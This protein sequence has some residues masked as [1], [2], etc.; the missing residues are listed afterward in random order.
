MH[1]SDFHFELPDELIARY[2]T[3]ERDASRLLHVSSDG[4]HHDRVFKDLV[5]LISPNDCLIFNN[6]KVIPARLLGKRESGGKVE[7][8]V[9]RVTGEFEFLSQVKS[10]NSLKPGA[11]IQVGDYLLSVIERQGLFYHLSSGPSVPIFEVLENEGH[12]PLPPY[13][14]RADTEFDAE[15]YQTVY[16]K[17]AG[18][19]AAP[20]AGL[21]FTDSILEKLKSKGVQWD[22]VTLHVGSGTFAPVRVDNIEQHQMHS[23]WFN[24]PESVVTLVNQTR[25]KGGRVIAVGTTSVRCLESAS[26]DGELNPKTGDTNIFIYPGYEFQCV[27]GLITNFH[28]PESTLIM[29]VSA[30]SGRSAILKAYQHAIEQKY[31][32]FSYGDAMFLEKASR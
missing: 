7:L 6:T 15:R 11:I 2:P 8:L 18:A 17:E 27:D 25:R 28:L 12:M 5:E 1:L 4:Q 26:V 9:E 3:E 32:F 30:F 13:I 20:T 23:E 29:L 21:H 16:A 22:F 19:V 14:D 10:S 24:V 31:R